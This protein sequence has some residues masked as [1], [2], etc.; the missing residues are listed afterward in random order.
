MRNH[1]LSISILAVLVQLFLSS[2]SFALGYTHN[3]YLC[4]VGMMNS[5]FSNSRGVDYVEYTQN[6]QVQRVGANTAWTSA[7]Q[8][9]PQQIMGYDRWNP[10][11]GIEEV[12]FALNSDY[13]GTQY[14]LEYCYMWDRQAPFDAVQ[15]STLFTPTLYAPIP[16]TTMTVDTKC[17][18]QFKNG[19]VIDNDSPQTPVVET[20]LDENKTSMRCTIRLTFKE[21]ATNIQRPHNSDLSAVNPQIKVKVDP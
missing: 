20:L 1:L 18:I 6:G 8:R 16:N 5:D 10:S 2:T 11:F 15:Y 4:D 7:F 14:Y 13:Y 12:T 3:I 9:A 19:S 17:S 21:T